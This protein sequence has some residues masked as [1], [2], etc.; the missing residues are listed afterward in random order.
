MTTAYDESAGHVKLYLAQG[1]IDF[2]VAKPLLNPGSA[3]RGHVDVRFLME[4]RAFD[5]FG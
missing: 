2:V 5:D 3:V 1:E 4:R